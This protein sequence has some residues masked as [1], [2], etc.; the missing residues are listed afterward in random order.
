MNSRMFDCL[1]YNACIVTVDRTFRVIEKGALAVM[2]RKIARVWSMDVDDSIPAARQTIDAGG[3][4]L[5]PGLVNAHTHL[6]MTLFR[7]LADDLPLMTWLEDYIFPA[8][9]RHINPENVYWASLLGC[10]ELLSAGVTTICDGY[11]MADKVIEAVGQAGLRAV[12][13]QGVI[14][15]P[16]PGVPDPSGNVE[17]AAQFVAENLLAGNDS[18]KPSIFCHSPYTCSAR[19]LKSAKQKALEAGVLFQIHLAET[20]A[21]LE[22]IFAE[23]GC[24]PAQWLEHLGILDSDTLLVHCVHLDKDDINLLAKTGCRVIHCPESNMKLAAGI[25]PVPEMLAAGI[26]VGLGTD[27]CASNN[28]LDLFGEMGTAARLHKVA[29]DDPTV[30]DAAGVVRMATIEGARCLGWEGQTGSLEVGKDADLIILDAKAPNL[31]PV[32]HAAS[33]IVYAARGSDVTHVMIA[34]RWVVLERRLLTLDINEV[35]EQVYK[36]SAAVVG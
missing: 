21:E 17:A 15:F 30:L 19:T 33:N 28:D 1:I 10:A 27:S 18:I 22:R 9:A 3:A 25:A 32:Y 8:E 34:G 4:I 23:H 13:G 29:S 36:R 35:V 16:A 20:R 2:D 6:P 14:D 11:F 31:I 24:S 12:A 5:M 26:C 7:G